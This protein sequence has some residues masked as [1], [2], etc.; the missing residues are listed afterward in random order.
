R[1]LMRFERLMRVSGGGTAGG[2]EDPRL[3]QRRVPAESDED[4]RRRRALC[5]LR[6]RSVCAIGYAVSRSPAI[7]PRSL[8]PGLCGVSR[9]R[10]PR[11]VAP[12]SG[13]GRTLAYRCEFATLPST[14]PRPPCRS[15]IRRSV[16]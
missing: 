6:H 3:I 10:D 13:E 12:R 5:Q 15:R 11:A 14:V 9:W 16:G 2:V 7:S 4:D 1:A 8:S